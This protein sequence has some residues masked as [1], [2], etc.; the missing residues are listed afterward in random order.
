MSKVVSW[1]ERSGSLPLTLFIWL[2][3]C[4]MDDWDPIVNVFNC[5]AS[6][7]ERLY[8]DPFS[9]FPRLSRNPLEWIHVDKWPSLQRIYASVKP[10]AVIPWAQLT[11]LQFCCDLSYAQMVH[12]FKGCRRLVWLSLSFRLVQTVFFDAPA[13]PIILRDLSFVSLRTNDLSAIIQLI[14]LPSLREISIYKTYGPADLGPL[15]L[16]PHFLTRSACTLDKLNIAGSLRS[17]D[18]LILILA[19][20]SCNLLT[21]LTVSGAQTSYDPPEVTLINEEVIWR[22]TLHH[23]NSACTHLK[24]LSLESSFRAAPI[25]QSALAKMVESRIGSRTGQ[26]QDGLLHLEI[27]LNTFDYRQLDEVIKRSEME[28]YDSKYRF[29]GCRYFVRL[30][31][32]GS[33]FS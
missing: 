1:I 5:Y 10:Y 24:S 30:H 31:R 18:D 4:I 29:V 8:I 21:S 25:S 9:A 14:S 11:H 19:H 33:N 7:W 27:R 15:K 12:I 28:V 16:L 3:R 26:L 17:P 13:S 22:L 23:G 2:R 32:R 20:R 6:R